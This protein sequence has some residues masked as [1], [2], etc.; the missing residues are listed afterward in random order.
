MRFKTEKIDAIEKAYITRD[1]LKGLD[2][3]EK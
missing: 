2:V 1:C 3:L